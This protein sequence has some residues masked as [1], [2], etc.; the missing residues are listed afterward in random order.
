MNAAWT[1]TSRRNFKLAKYGLPDEVLFCQRCVISNQRPS[2]T[3]EY[4]HVATSVKET[5]RFEEGVCDAC[6][7]AEAKRKTDWQEREQQLQRLCAIYRSKRG[8]YD[9]IF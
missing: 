9:F 7:V 4:S 8:D 6:R 5:I 2:S 3:V 1:S